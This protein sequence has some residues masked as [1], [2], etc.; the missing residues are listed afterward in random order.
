[1]SR[2]PPRGRLKA[3]AL[4]LLRVLNSPATLRNRG[5]C[6]LGN[7][8]TTMNDK[9]MT[10]LAPLICFGFILICFSPMFFIHSRRL[11]RLRLI[12]EVDPNEEKRVFHRQRGEG[13]QR[14]GFIV[15]AEEGADNFDNWKMHVRCNAGMSNAAAWCF[16]VLF[17]IPLFITRTGNGFVCSLYDGMYSWTSWIAPGLALVSFICA[18]SASEHSKKAR[19]M[20]KRIGL[21]KG[22]GWLKDPE[23]ITL[24]LSS[25]PEE[26]EQAPMFN[27]L[28]RQVIK[29]IINGTPIEQAAA[30]AGL[31]IDR[32]MVSYGAF[33]TAY[34][35][36]PASERQAFRERESG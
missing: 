31:T 34:N 11:K 20:G 7:P 21:P 9:L 26:V 3:T 10:F 28:E 13:G 12:K 1:M 33:L 6:F 5:G 23:K 29:A 4:V 27:Q 35:E 25:L 17:L 16:A 2:F 15:E 18:V 22:F 24:I 14:L 36:Q 30:Q 32:A 19:I 8:F